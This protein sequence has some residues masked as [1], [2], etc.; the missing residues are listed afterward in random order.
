MTRVEF[1]GKARSRPEPGPRKPRTLMIATLI[2]DDGN[3]ELREKPCL[4]LEWGLGAEGV[5]LLS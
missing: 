5:S 1:T 2:P 4:G 3:P